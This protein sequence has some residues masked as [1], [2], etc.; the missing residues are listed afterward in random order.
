M[1]SR[2]FCFWLQGYFELVETNNSKL[3]KSQIQVIQD[4]L[5]LVFKKETPDRSI[6]GKPSVKEKEKDNLDKSLKDLLD[7]Y[8]KDRK[9]K[10]PFK[11]PWPDTTPFPQEPRWWIDEVGDVIPNPYEITCSFTTSN[12]KDTT[13][14]C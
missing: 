13:L 3:T 2:D 8:E 10:P 4:H 9:N 5:K 6:A 12:D 11:W 7:E 14:I 1:N